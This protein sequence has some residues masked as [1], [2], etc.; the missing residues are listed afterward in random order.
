MNPMKKSIVAPL[1]LL[2]VVLV[3][4]ALIVF[5][6]PA[7]APQATASYGSVNAVGGITYYLYGSGIGSSDTT[8]TLTSFKQPVSQYNLAM[9]DFGS[10][11]YLTLEPGNVR[12]QEFISFT[13]LVTNSDGTATLTGVTRGLS[14][15]YPFTASSTIQQEHG[16]GTTAVISNPPQFYERFA[17]KLNAQTISALWTFASTAPPAYDA[18]PVWA[19]F[20][21]KAF[22]DVAY[23]NSVVAGGAANASETVKGIVQL[24]TGLQAASSTSLGSTGARLAL[25]ANIAT[26]TPNTAT[27]GSKLLVSTIGGFLS[28]S[29]LDLT[30]NWT[31]TG[32]ISILASVA[33]PFTLNSVAYAWPSSQGV[34]NSRLQ[35][36]GAGNLS[37]A[38]GTLK[39]N[40]GTTTAITVAGSGAQATSTSL[41][42]PANVMT[43]SSTILIQASISQAALGSCNLAI[44]DGIG[45][46][47]VSVNTGSPPSGNTWQV[48][49]NGM[50]LS[51]NSTASQISALNEVSLTGGTINAI[52]GGQISSGS[53]ATSV[54]LSNAFVLKGVISTNSSN[55]CT[56]N[57]LFMTV[58]P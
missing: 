8:I 4:I 45:D 3:G 11:G 7:P 56:L 12:R 34:A 33:K 19:N 18:D 17:N 10:I 42:I 20:S 22:A 48:A 49:I 21:T 13:S 55:T 40:Y 43:A 54:N 28:Q 32:A 57:N 23:V 44:E 31:F 46:T 37:W 41:S 52:A 51:N 16:G 9:A 38:M 30:A 15:V 36:D 25:G 39:F 14:P 29:W 6:K 50:I 26:D 53:S 27:R 58:T 47:F 2:A 24:A 5:P 1:A 35:N